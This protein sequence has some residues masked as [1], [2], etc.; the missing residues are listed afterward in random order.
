MRDI[1]VNFNYR[2]FSLA[3]IGFLTIDSYGAQ[4]VAKLGE[5]ASKS[6][7]ESVVV[8]LKL[9]LTA[10]Q[11]VKVVEAYHEKKR[12]E[13]E[14]RIELGRMA[15]R[16]QQ[17]YEARQA[18]ESVNQKL[19]DD[20]VQL[21]ARQTTLWSRFKET[22]GSIVSTCRNSIFP[23]REPIDPRLPFWRKG[24]AIIYNNVRFIA[25]CAGVGVLYTLKK[26]NFFFKRK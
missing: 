18:R 26:N 4:G 15:R 10:E 7:N 8:G 6:A 9:P 1:I 24:I 3:I 25:V 14:A 20:N 23:Q 21:P 13:R 5:G 19:R 16:S 22:V 17:F 2:I 12:K 11:A